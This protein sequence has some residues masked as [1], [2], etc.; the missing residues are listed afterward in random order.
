M[1]FLFGEGDIFFVK[2]KFGKEFGV[3]FYLKNE[4]V[5]LIWSFKDRGMFLVVS[6]VVKVGYKVIGMVFIGN[7]VVSVVV[8]VVRV[9][10]K[11]KI[12]V[13]ESVSEEKFKIVSVYGV[14]VIRVR[15]DYGRFY[16]ESLELGEKFGIYFINFDN[17]FCVEGYKG[18]VF[19]MVEE[20]IFDYV[21]IFMSLGGLFRGIVKGFIE[22]KESGF[23]EKFLMLIVV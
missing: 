20:F 10:L 12:F 11:V 4:I 1:D 7:M 5:N 6:Y 14:D 19:E 22:L 13:L 17:L 18:I 9:G 15:G 8:Y 16:F 21:L 2:F 3:K 23:I